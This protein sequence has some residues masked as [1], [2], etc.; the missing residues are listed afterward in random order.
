MGVFA[1]AEGDNGTGWANE[2]YAKLLDTAN[3][4]LEVGERNRLLS[5]AEN[6]LMSEQ[7][8]IPL[9]TTSTNWLKKPFVKGMYPNALTLHAWKFVYLERDPANW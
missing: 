6:L 5:E 2:R 7:P 9:T 3:Q 1:T 8:I 4:T